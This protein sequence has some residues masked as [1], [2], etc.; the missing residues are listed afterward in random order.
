MRQLLR[1]Y[2]PPPADN[3]SAESMVNEAVPPCLLGHYTPNYLFHPSTAFNILEVFPRDVLDRLKFIVLLR[4]PSERCVSSYWYK[5]QA[6]QETRSLA[7]AVDE[8]ISKSR[9]RHEHRMR[10]LDMRS[11][12]RE[13]TAALRSEW[14][15][16]FDLSDPSKIFLEHVGKGMYADQITLWFLLFRPDQ[17]VFVT[18][19]EMKRAPELA[20]GRVLTFLGLDEQMEPEVARSSR[21]VY[22]QRRTGGA[23]QRVVI[24]QAS[25]SS[26]SEPEERAAAKRSVGGKDGDGARELKK[27]AR[28]LRSF[29]AKH[30]Q[31]LFKLLGRRLWS[32][33]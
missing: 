8:G 18:L 27:A 6:G 3:A 31:E 21:C 7:Q 4:E 1:S 9:R 33:T 25:K 11:L 13:G 26:A 20:V 22:N 24:A 5:R 32:S 19:N 10:S 17:F 23:E 16:M 30:D 12:Q 28:K 14:E 15:S 29:Y 2:T